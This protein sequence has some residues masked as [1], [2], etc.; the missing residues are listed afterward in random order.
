MTKHQSTDSHTC[1]F[2]L[3]KPMVMMILWSPARYT[4]RTDGGVR[5]EVVAAILVLF[6][7]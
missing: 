4:A 2:A 7:K 5:D 1:S 6:A 3:N